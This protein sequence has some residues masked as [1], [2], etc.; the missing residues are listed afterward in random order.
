[1]TINAMNVVGGMHKSQFVYTATGYGQFLIAINCFL[2]TAPISNDL[3]EFC[4]Q[5]QLG[6]YLIINC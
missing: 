6:H 5:I 3:L 1:M 4:L 2:Y